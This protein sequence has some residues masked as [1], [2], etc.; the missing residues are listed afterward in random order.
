MSRVGPL[1]AV[2]LVVGNRA[3]PISTLR[4]LTREDPDLRRLHPVIQALEA[5]HPLPDALRQ[6]RLLTRAEAT[7]LSSCGAEAL[8]DALGR[9]AQAEA[10][11]P[12]GGALL[13]WFPLWALLAGTVP[14]LGIGLI[15]ALGGGGVYRGLFS[16][17]SPLSLAEPATGWWWCVQ[18]GALALA[19]LIVAGIAWGL[20][21]VKGLWRFLPCDLPTARATALVDLLED[22]RRGRPCQRS[23]K[24]WCWFSGLSEDATWGLEQMGGDH[25]ATVMGL[26]LLP[27]R[28]DGQPD[29]PRAIASAAQA[30]AVALARVRPI[31][32]GLLALVGLVGLLGWSGPWTLIAYVVDFPQ[33]LHTGF[34]LASHALAVPAGAAL[35][36][37]MLLWC[38]GWLRLGLA[39]LVEGAAADWPLVAHRLADALDRREDLNRTLHQLQAWTGWA[40][41]HRLSLARRH[42]EPHPGR[43]LAAARVAP[44]SVASVLA[45]TPIEALPAVLRSSV[46]EPHAVVD[47]RIAGQVAV[48]LALLLVL[49]GVVGTTLPKLQ[50]MAKYTVSGPLVPGQLL[51]VILLGVAAGLGG[52]ILVLALARRWGWDLWLTGHRR[53]ANGMRLRQALALRLPEAHLGTDTDLPTILRRAGWPCRTL[54]DLDRAL[55]ADLHRR[56]WA[57]H[58]RTV[59]VALFLPVL[60]GI[61]VGMLGISIFQLTNACNERVQRGSTPPLAGGSLVMWTMHQHLELA[62]QRARLA[63]PEKAP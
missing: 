27:H 17:I 63:Q 46:A 7:S 3:E 55:A 8:A 12:P 42:E 21:R 32:T 28:D 50:L 16:V 38:L 58:R 10:E 23:W 52:T 43:R 41:T 51:P 36:A 11:P 6:A 35:A 60:L 25:R 62:E 26:G 14:S 9:L 57:T 1:A 40:M 19:A 5:G 39:T 49:L 4:R 47:P 22:L 56:R 31:A 48:G 2:A 53:L 54:A 34:S 61:P 30:Q 18:A 44:H 33:W 20:P 15:V 13:R 59:I 37:V 45:S 24:R 29:F